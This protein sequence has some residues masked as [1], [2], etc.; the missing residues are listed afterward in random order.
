M[1]PT[2]RRNVGQSTSIANEIRRNLDNYGDSQ[3]IDELLQ[4]ADDA[5]AT[6]ACFMLDHRQH[7]TSTLFGPSMAELQGP[8]FVSFD[9]AVFQPEDFVGLRSFGRGSKTYNPT[10]TGMF[11]LGFNSVY[12]VTEVPMFVTGKHFVVLD[13][14]AKYVPGATAHAAGLETEWA[15]EDYS[16]VA[17][18]FEPFNMPC[19]GCDMTQKAATGAAGSAGAGDIALLFDDFKRKLP[20]ALLFMQSLEEV[21]LF[22]WHHGAAAPTSL[23]RVQL[24]GPQLEHRRNLGGWLRG[25]LDGWSTKHDGR[26]WQC[27]RTALQEVLRATSPGKIPRYTIKV[28]MCVEEAGSS[29]TEEWWIRTGVGNGQAWKMAVDKD[30]AADADWVLWPLSVTEGKAFATLSTGIA[31]GYPVHVNARWRLTNNRNALIHS[32]RSNQI[33]NKWNRFLISDPIASLWAELLVELTAS[34][35]LA[36]STFYSLWP[37]SD[38]ITDD[39]YW[40][41]VHAPVYKKLYSQPVML[42]RTSPGVGPPQYTALSDGGLF[43]NLLEVPEVDGPGKIRIAWLNL[44]LRHEAMQN[45]LSSSSSSSSSSSISRSNRPVR[46]YSVE[47]PGNRGI[48]RFRKIAKLVCQWIAERGNLP[49]TLTKDDCPWLLEAPHSLS[50]EFKKADGGLKVDALPHHVRDFYRTLAQEVKFTAVPLQQAPFKGLREGGVEAVVGVLRCCT[51]DI[52]PHDA[53]ALV[54]LPI[55]PSSEGILIKTGTQPIL[56]TPDVATVGFLTGGAAVCAHPL[57]TPLLQPFARNEDAAKLLQVRQLDTAV[58]GDVLK[59][60]VP[61][62]AGKTVVDWNPSAGT[63]VSESWVRT[64]FRWLDKQNAGSDVYVHHLKGLAILP[65]FTI[66][67]GAYTYKSV[68]IAPQ[69]AADCIGDVPSTSTSGGGGAATATASSGG[70]DGSGVRGETQAMGASHARVLDLLVRIGIPVLQDGYEVP[71]ASQV[72]TFSPQATLEV[73]RH[74]MQL[75]AKKES[76]LCLDFS[77][78]KSSDVDDLLHYFAAAGLAHDHLELLQLLPI[79]ELATPS[80]EEPTKKFVAIAGVLNVR[81][82]PLFA[83]KTDLKDGCFL[84]A[85]PGCETLYQSLGIVP[86]KQSELY[87]NHIFPKFS[88]MTKEMRMEAMADVR[89]SLAQLCAEDREFLTKL[90]ELPWVQAQSTDSKLYRCNELFDRNELVFRDFFPDRIPPRSMSEWVPFMLQLGL[91]KEMSRPLALE[92]AKRAA[93]ERNPVKG[94][95]IIR[96]VV[97]QLEELC[98]GDAA[99][100]KR[101]LDAFTALPLVAGYKVS[102]FGKPPTTAAEAKQAASDPLLPLNQVALKEEWLVCWTVRPV[103]ADSVVTGYLTQSMR[104][105]VN[106]RLRIKPV[107]LAEMLQHLVQMC[108]LAVDNPPVSSSQKFTLR[109]AVGLCYEIIAQNVDTSAD[110]IRDALAGQK[111][112]LLDDMFTD[113]EDMVFVSADMLFFDLKHVLKEYGYQFSLVDSALSQL[114]AWRKL[115]ALLGVR[116]RPEYAD[117]QGM[118]LGVQSRHVQHQQQLQRQGRVSTG[119]LSEADVELVVSILS[120]VPEE[121]EIRQ[122]RELLAVD[123]SGMMVRIKELVLNDAAWLEPRIDASKISIANKALAKIPTIAAMIEPLSKAVQESLKPGFKPNTVVSNA[124]VE[125]WSSTITSTWFRE[126]VRRILSDRPGD[127]LEMA[128]KKSAARIAVYQLANLKLT[129]VEKLQSKFVLARSGHDVTKESTGSMGLVDGATLYLV[130]TGRKHQNLVE[131]T[132]QLNRILGDCIQDLQPL[133]LLLTLEDQSEADDLLTMLRVPV[134]HSNDALGVKLDAASAAR[135]KKVEDLVA[136]GHAPTLLQP[137]VDVAWLAS[138]GSGGSGYQLARLIEMDGANSACTIA[139]D[140]TGATM[141]LPVNEV[142]R[143]LSQ[144]ELQDLRGKQATRD[145]PKRGGGSNDVGGGGLLAG[146]IGGT[147]AGVP[148]LLASGSNAELSDSDGS[149][150]G[151]GGG[152]ARR[153]EVNLADMINALPEPAPNTAELEDIARGEQVQRVKYDPSSADNPA[154]ANKKWLEQEAKVLESLEKENRKVEAT[155]EEEPL[156]TD[157]L[158]VQD[159]VILPGDLGKGN[160]ELLAPIDVKLGADVKRGYDLVRVS[161]V[162]GVAFF[163]QRTVKCPER[164]T[165]L[166]KEIVEILEEVSAVFD[167]NPKYVTLFWQPGS[168]SRFI[169]QKLMYNIW[170]IEDHVI[171]KKVKSVKKDPFAYCYFYGL[172]I[173]KLGHFHD[174]VHGTRHD[175]FMNELR[176]EFLMEWLALL[177]RHGFDPGLLEMSPLGEK[178][179]KET[180]F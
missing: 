94:R 135:L 3:I 177:D 180:V 26:P 168:L 1:P 159:G 108:K 125:R 78:L 166:L 68:L 4:N 146:G 155:L 171:S 126:G 164:R 176:I 75:D 82:L 162:K 51:T 173:H 123:D 136:D 63:P 87:T 9:N 86:L 145:T 19:F 31:T 71:E 122:L 64:L 142:M 57:A 13:P 38:A 29:W 127:T 178:C 48:V 54:G 161:N 138:G 45:M 165:K 105:T 132:I 52:A 12:H 69:L 84:K 25:Q 8:A 129:A 93:D 133:S 137:G 158:L 11:G 79:F 72:R 106:E 66:A 32:S 119:K 109:K 130:L 114:T 76:P 139:V 143:L 163:H 131:L 103:M 2:A 5:K 154:G 56:I 95:Y 39:E 23:C 157:E 156:G 172:F 46:S 150:G 15:T 102:I 140:S 16:A 110:E 151:G 121:T 81:L 30:L 41:L 34:A 21:E 179:L 113:S 35:D 47:D 18:Q 96:S 60:T 120:S 22:E 55:I 101:F 92:C 89:L 58:L 117:L 80:K 111:C 67:N 116:P 141:T 27:E 7:G 99:E 118:L 91:Q 61:A 107:K 17:D 160:A 50:H 85:K 149:G 104:A 148:G 74:I 20:E 36:P 40:G 24:Y 112:L 169:K 44:I 53:K 43:E 77:W 83:P 62:V 98:Q 175:F 153:Q 174:I 128:S 134:Q 144:N 70:D 124:K 65:A 73:M 147:D 33:Y 6:R 115:A 100:V 28:L 170:P 152:G 37:R 10:K 88:S 42:Q 97:E 49:S 90:K 59:Q 14:Q 167:Y